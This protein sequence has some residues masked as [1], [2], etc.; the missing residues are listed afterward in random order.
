MMA[1]IISSI[2]VARTGVRVDTDLIEHQIPYGSRDPQDYRISRYYMASASTVKM[3]EGVNIVVY[4]RHRVP[5][6]GQTVEP[7]KVQSSPLFERAGT[8]GAPIRYTAKWVEFAVAPRGTSYFYQEVIYL[9]VPV[10]WVQ[11]GFF[12]SI[13][14][15]WRLWRGY[16]AVEDIHIFYAGQELAMDVAH[17]SSGA[18]LLSIGL[19]PPRPENL[20]GPMDIPSVFSV[21]DSD[22]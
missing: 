6:E 2:G 3:H 1:E 7:G 14:F 21:T 12:G 17:V 16:L 4:E 19:A 22:E 9:I 20:I 5:A 8:L 13:Y 18:S 10:Q 11:L 15:H